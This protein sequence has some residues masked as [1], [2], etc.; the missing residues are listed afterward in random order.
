MP[1]SIPTPYITMVPGIISAT[2]ALINLTKKK[3][4]PS[5]KTYR[6]TIEKLKTTKNGDA[7]FT[8]GFKKGGGINCVMFQGRYKFPSSIKCGEKVLIVLDDEKYSDK[9]QAKYIEKITTGTSI[10]KGYIYAAIAIIFIAA[11]IVLSL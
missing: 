6:G 1:F 7:F 8:L 9:Y 2:C 4:I 11:S 3:D 10:N 5:G